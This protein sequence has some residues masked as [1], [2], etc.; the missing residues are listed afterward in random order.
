[1]RKPVDLASK[2]GYTSGLGLVDV[3]QIT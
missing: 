1:M 3:M 2:A